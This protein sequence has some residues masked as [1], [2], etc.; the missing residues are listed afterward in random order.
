NSNII[1]YSKVDTVSG[2]VVLVVVNLDPRN[3]QEATV[4][5]DM[6]AIGRN[7]GEV[8]T[9]QDVITG[10]AYSWS[11]RNFVRLEPL[12]DVAHVF[13]LPDADAELREQ[14]AWREVTDYRP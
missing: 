4:D 6:A 9:V 11:N 2:N 7:P 13:I 10:A 14:I 5:I 1:A 3:P 12:R 8:Y